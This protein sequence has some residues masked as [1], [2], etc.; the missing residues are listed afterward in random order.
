[1]PIA[2]EDARHS[3]VLRLDRI[4]KVAQHI[5]GQPSTAGSL[6]QQTARVVREANATG[7]VNRPRCHVAGTET[8]GA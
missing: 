1:M 6:C 3:H 4:A 5:A 2:E 7:T 8:I